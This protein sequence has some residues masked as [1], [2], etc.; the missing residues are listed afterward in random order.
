MRL[1]IGC[2]T[3]YPQVCKPLHKNLIY[4]QSHDVLETSK[5]SAD[6]RS[7]LLIFVN[8]RSGGQQ[9]KELARIF[10]NM[11]SDDQ[12][13]D[14]DQSGGPL[15]ALKH[16][17]NVQNLKILV[18][19]GDGSIGWVLQC[20]DKLNLKIPV[21]IL[22]LGTGNDLARTLGWGT[23]YDEEPLSFLLNQ[24]EHASITM[25]D[26]WKI[27]MSME[28]PDKKEKIKEFVMNNYMSIGI[29]A[30]VALDFHNLRQKN[31]E[32]CASQ[33]MNKFWYT[34][35]GAIA[36]FQGLENLE[37]MVTVQ[38]DG[39]DVVLPPELEGI[40]ILNVPNYAG[41]AN[42][43][44]DEDEPMYKK[45]A[46]DDKLLEVT[47]IT[48]SFHMGSITCHLTSAIRVAQGSEINIKLRT[49]NP[50]PMQIDGEPMTQP[51][52]DITIQHLNQASMLRKDDTH[53]K[54]PQESK[55]SALS[56]SNHL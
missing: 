14:L 5:D 17:R 10:K 52:C 44:G 40:I 3:Y 37:K 41:G 43:W 9:G 11:L 48:G 39:K 45:P 6:G 46:I 51:S 24:V 20:L 35:Y 32:L 50:L 31:P 15:P 30:Q 13:I 16:F 36:I 42:L 18:C 7:P 55:I 33:L 38:A 53:L 12:V 22:P 19:G 4:V 54:A 29:D 56:R 28:N 47:A 2:A 1:H 49:L 23:G 26:R 27:K 34:T 25:I 21:G 8:T